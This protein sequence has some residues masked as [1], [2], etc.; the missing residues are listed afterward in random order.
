[1]TMASMLA[2]PRWVEAAQALIDGCV[3]L[4]TEDDRVEF[5]ISVCQ[6]LGDGLYPALLRILW[7]I[8]ERGDHAACAAVS[9]ALVHS[10]RTGRLPSG[11]RGVWGASS[12]EDAYG[13]SRLLGPIEYLCVWHTQGEHGQALA[14]EHFQAA[15]RAILT[16]LSSDP[17]ARALYCEKLLADVDDPLSGSLTRRTR[18]ALRALAQAW[19]RGASADD[20]SARFLAALSSAPTLMPGALLAPPPGGMRTL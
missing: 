3:D 16:L 7:V 11:R 8:G 2:E 13:A 18:A 9:G 20:A 15:A 12:R 4:P 6:R 17:A 10:L 5:L 19:S 14:T 1:V